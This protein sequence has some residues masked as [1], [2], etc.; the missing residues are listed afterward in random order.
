[1]P[2]RHVHPLRVRYAEC[3]AQSVVFNAHYLAYFDI[4]LTELWRA[5]L[6]SYG[7]M[8]EQ[9]VDVVVAEATVRFRRAAR[10]DD[11]LDL[12]IEVL[13]L[14]TTSMQTRHRVLRD[15]EALVEGDMVHVFVR[16]DGSGKTPIPDWIRAAL[17]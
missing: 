14:G 3:D 8:V 13:R 10:F 5:A 15:G 9:G 12:E 16:T 17:S 6:G 2:A 11:I 4:A 7:A 1:M